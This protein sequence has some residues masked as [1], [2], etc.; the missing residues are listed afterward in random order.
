M[1]DSSFTSS[2]TGRTPTRSRRKE[3]KQFQ[4]LND[5]ATSNRASVLEVFRDGPGGPGKPDAELSFQRWRL[6]FLA[7][8][9]LFG[10][11]EGREWLVGHYRFR[12]SE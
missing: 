7:C 10:Y 2:A 5:P 12:P 11:E 9:E 6:F 3:R 4:P 1:L 8:E